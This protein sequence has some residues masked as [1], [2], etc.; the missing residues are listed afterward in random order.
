MLSDEI[1]SVR[2]AA[3]AALEALHDKVPPYTAG[4]VMGRDAP[5][6]TSTGHRVL[7]VCNEARSLTRRVPDRVYATLDI[8]RPYGRQC[9]M[10][11]GGGLRIR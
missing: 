5:Q 9:R 7:D 2:L 3:I 1:D 6:Y 4:H 8:R 11:I 10:D